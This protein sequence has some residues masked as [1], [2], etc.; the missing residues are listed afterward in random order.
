[1]RDQQLR[2]LVTAENQYKLALMVAGH[3]HI[4]GS[5]DSKCAAFSFGPYLIG[6]DDLRL[7]EEEQARAAAALEVSAVKVLAIAVDTAL[8]HV[9]P[10]RFTHADRAIAD[11]AIIARAIRNAFAHDP[12]CPR[13]ELRNPRHAGRFEIPGVIILDTTGKD[14]H[15]VLWQ[16]YGGPLALLCLLQHARLLIERSAS[17]A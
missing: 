10:D 1:M 4:E 14:G 16:D 3:V 13:W 9:F 7:D 11:T 2:S 17:A 12:I 6:K 15:E 8:E 5:F